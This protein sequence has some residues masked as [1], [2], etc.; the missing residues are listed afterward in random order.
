MAKPGAKPFSCGAQP[1]KKP[2]LLFNARFQLF[3]GYTPSEQT[4]FVCMCV[5]VLVSQVLS[6]CMY[7]RVLITTLTFQSCVL[8]L[9]LFLQCIMSNVCA[10]ALCKPVQYQ[11]VF[12]CD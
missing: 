8:V 9:L 7:V 6:M 12:S 11:C 1:F 10:L 2:R 5:Y 4:G 3:L